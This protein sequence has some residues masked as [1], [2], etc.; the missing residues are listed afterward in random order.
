[1]ETDALLH[2][3]TRPVHPPSL[4]PTNMD[5]SVDHERRRPGALE[6]RNPPFHHPCPTFFSFNVRILMGRVLLLLVA[7]LYGTLSVTIRF[8]YQLSGPPSASALCTARGWLAALCFLPFLW[9]NKGHYKNQQTLHEQPRSSSN[10]AG[11]GESGNQWVEDPGDP[12]ITQTASKGGHEDTTSTA[13]VSSSSLSPVEQPSQ[14]QPHLW[15]IALELAGWNFGAQGLVALGLLST[16]SARASFL[17]QTSVVMT[18]V[19]SAVAGQTVAPT[20]WI[21]CVVAFLGLMFLSDASSSSSSLEEGGED[22]DGIRNNNNNKGGVGTDISIGDLIVLSGSMCWSLYIFRLSSVGDR[23][24]EIEL[25]AAKTFLLALLYSGWLSVSMMIMLVAPSSDD[26]QLQPQQEVGIVAGII[27]VIGADL[28]KQ[29]PGWTSL[30]AWGLIF[31]SALGPGTIAD[32]MQ[33]KGQ[34]VIHASESNIV[35]SMEPVFTALLGQAIL[36][37]ATTWQEKLGGGLIVGAAVIAT[38][39]AITMD[40][41]KL[42]VNKVWWHTT[43]LSHSPH[44]NAGKRVQ[45]AGPWN[46]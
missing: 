31:Y 15:W 16:K 26:E 23:Y 44:R 38:Q 37:E 6:Q 28:T 11:E 17:T 32:V 22:S 43:H 24:D 25:Q 20:V 14:K 3:K 45:K 8:V 19:V 10:I 18:P 29:W 5:D 33:Q 30:A 9:M 27:Y 34:A 13:S 42:Q 21:A 7:F 1:M 46:L 41:L 40:S 35:L 39:P 36:G 4:G 2:T 12:E